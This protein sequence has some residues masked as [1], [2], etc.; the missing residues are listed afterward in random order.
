MER[1]NRFQINTLQVKS[2][3]FV[4]EFFHHKGHKVHEGELRFSFVF[5]RDLRG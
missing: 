1:R 3:F 4:Q 5:L 2:L